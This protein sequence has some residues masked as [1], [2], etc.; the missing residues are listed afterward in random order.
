MK[1][2]LPRGRQQAAPF[3]LRYW[4][5]AVVVGLLGG[6]AGSSL[7]QAP[8]PTTLRLVAWESRGERLLAGTVDLL[9]GFHES[10]PDLRLNLTH[11]DWS[12]AHTRLRYWSGSLRGY[13]PDMTI[14][15]DRWLA[16]F[17]GSLLPLDDHLTRLDLQGF[18]PAVLDR[19]RVDGKL[20]GV[21]WVTRSLALYYRA[22]LLEA[23]KLAPPQT[24]EEL[25]SVALRLRELAGVHGVGLAAEEAGGAAE[26]FLALLGAYG[27]EI[28][29]GQGRLQLDTP[30]ALQALEYWQGLQRSGATQPEMLQWS[31]ADLN[32]AFAEGKVGM[33]IAGPELA[34]HL[35]N[36]RPQLRFGVT[37][38]PAGSQQAA[39]INSEVLVV[40]RSSRYTADAVRFVKFMCRPQSQRAMSL[41]G[42]IPTQTA[43]LAEAAKAPE[44]AAFVSGLAQARG[45]PVGNPE[46]VTLAL[47]RVLYLTLS[48]RL[49]ARSALSF[50]AAEARSKPAEE[51]STAGGQ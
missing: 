14:V 6:V 27:G 38:L 5:P 36:Q 19:C 26:T 23:Q 43:Q 46:A 7:A 16:Q 37:A 42:G 1:Q 40:W 22:D 34:R 25:Q 49:D 15:R 45:L 18:V 28:V 30:Q 47:E 48:G 21:P 20:L 10:T 4:W 2:V 3:G 8:P 39:Q 51:G 29:D 31:A 35:K 32:V 17:A 41:I 13:A 24:L 33:I 9:A 11:E 50:V 44:Q 12:Q